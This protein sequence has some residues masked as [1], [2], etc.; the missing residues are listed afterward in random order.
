MRRGYPKDDEKGIEDNQ[1]A[2]AN[3]QNQTTR[4]KTKAQYHGGKLPSSKA[5]LTPPT[6]PFLTT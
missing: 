2:T 3:C 1:N 5:D 4:E 6:P